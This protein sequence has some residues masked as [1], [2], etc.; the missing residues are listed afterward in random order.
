M[1]N[2][3]SEQSKF[4]EASATLYVIFNLEYPEGRKVE[5][6]GQFGTEILNITSN[7]KQFLSLP[8]NFKLEYDLKDSSAGVSDKSIDWKISYKII[9]TSNPDII[10]TKSGQIQSFGVQ[11]YT[12]VNTK[13][14]VATYTSDGSLSMNMKATVYPNSTEILESKQQ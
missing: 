6:L 4:V 12:K 5:E 7:L 3:G 8:N 1:Q 11:G 2:N 13:T 10:K 14:N 9:D